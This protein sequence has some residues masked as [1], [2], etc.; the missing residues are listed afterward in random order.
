MTPSSSARNASLALLVTG[1]INFAFYAVLI[2][3]D[4]PLEPGHPEAVRALSRAQTWSDT[5]MGAASIAGGVGIW[6]R[7]SW[8]P[9]FG[10]VGAAAL[11]HMGLT[12]IAMFAQH[13]LYADPSTGIKIMTVVDGWALLVGSLV[14]WSLGG[15]QVQCS[16]RARVASH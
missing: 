6:L 8:A 5:Y 14:V 16:V 2:A 10:I 3:M 1:V 11:V 4:Y 7:W 13:D 9:I 15:E 12:D